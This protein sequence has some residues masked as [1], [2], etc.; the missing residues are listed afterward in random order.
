MNLLETLKHN[1]AAA[2]SDTKAYD[3]PIVCTSLGLADGDQQE[4][5]ASKYKYVFRRVRTLSKDHSIALAK[6]ILQKG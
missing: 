6:Q 3:L 1:I 5:Y 4:A 2:L